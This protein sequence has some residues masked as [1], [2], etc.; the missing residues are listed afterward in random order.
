VSEATSARGVRRHIDAHG[1][2]FAAKAIRLL[3]GF[4]QQRR[5]RPWTG[6]GGK[7]VGFATAPA[8]AISKKFAIS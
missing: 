2:R 6:N 7:G 8:G 4:A 5:R 1:R 3:V